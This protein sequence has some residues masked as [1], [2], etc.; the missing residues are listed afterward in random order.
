M[1]TFVNIFFWRNHINLNISDSRYQIIT[2]YGDRKI[3]C[4]ALIHSPRNTSRSHYVTLL[5][6]MTSSD[7]NIFRVTGPLCG[8][9]TGPGELPTQRPVTRS[10]DVFLDLRLNKQSWGWWIETLSRPLWRHRNV[11]WFISKTMGPACVIA[12]A[13]ARLCE[14]VGY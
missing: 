7:G 9:F 12:E 10:F 2:S 14:W 8:E 3:T 11:H 5:F 13:A 6:L 4:I 1:S